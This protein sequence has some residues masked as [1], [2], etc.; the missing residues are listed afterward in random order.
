MKKGTGKRSI[1]WFF[2]KMLL[3]FVVLDLLMI[4]FANLMAQ[5][6]LLYKYGQEMLIEMF[7]AIAILIVMLLFKN[8]YVFTDRK[9]KFWTSITLGLPMLVISIINF[10]VNIMNLSGFNLTS[11]VNVILYCFLIGIAEE[12]LCRGWL[13]N[14]FIER[15]STTKK[16]VIK[17]IILASLVFG[18][19]HI[20]NVKSQPLFETILQIINATTLGILLGSIYYKTK[21]IWAVIFLH[22]FYDFA[23]FLEEVNYVKDCSYGVATVPIQIVS[24]ISILLIS[25]LWVLSALYVINKIEF[26]DDRRLLKARNKTNNVLSASIVIVFILLLVPLEQLVPD[27]KDYKTCYTYNE[28]IDFEEYEIHFPNYKSYTIEN[29]DSSYV[30]NDEY[31]GMLDGNS[32]KY[33]FKLNDNKTINIENKMTGYEA[34]IEY[35]NI[36]KYVVLEYDDYYLLAF[37]TPNSETTL[38]ISSYIRK[39]SMSND[40]TYLDNINSSFR[41]YKLPKIDEFGY[42]T[43]GENEKYIYLVSEHQDR[44]VLIGRDLYLI[45]D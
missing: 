4:I 5:S 33:T 44:F 11:F 18:F 12:F 16:D 34:Q 24:T 32:Y 19:M 10:S 36:D 31:S 15:F 28:M 23:L 42:I 40:N 30:E 13:Q 41:S 14:E 8:S 38:Y 7:Y 6:T 25:L 2:I 17:S 22:S 21:N 45:K 35:V 3:I 29:V 26:D 43:L 20:I 37:I 9:E 39:D 27:Y 1:L